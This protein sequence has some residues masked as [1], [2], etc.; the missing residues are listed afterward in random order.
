[1]INA[2]CRRPTVPL[3]LHPFLSFV[4]YSSFF[5]L[6]WDVEYS[7]LSALLCTVQAPKAG[8]YAYVVTPKASSLNQEQKNFK[9][10]NKA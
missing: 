6:L 9:K 1:V 10:T 7:S 2:L 5:S 3:S 8:N 4:G